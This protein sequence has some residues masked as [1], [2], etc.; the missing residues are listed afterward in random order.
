MS[1]LRKYIQGKD[2]FLSGSGVT[3]TATSITLTSFQFPDGTNITTSDIGS[4][5]YG[6][7]EPE[8]SRE[9]NFSFTTITQ[10]ADGTATLSGVTRGLKFKAPYDQDTAL[11]QTHAGGTKVRISNSVPFY[12]EFA[13]TENDE[14]ISQTW[15]FTNPNYPRM[16][17][18]T[19][20]PIDDEQLATKKYVDDTAGGTPVS[21]NR[22]VVAGT[23]GETVSAGQVVYLDETDNEWKLAD[24]STSA[25]SDNVQLGIA[26]GAG[27]NGNPITGGVLIV[28]RDSNQSG[29]SAGDRVYVGDT[30]GAIVTSAGTV[31]VELGHAVSATAI[32][33][34]PKFA[35]YTTKLQRD[36]LIGTSGTPSTSNKYVTADD[37]TEAKTASKIARRDSNSDILVATTPTAGDAATSK[38]YVDTEIS[39][40]QTEFLIGS[41]EKSTT[42]TNSQLDIERMTRAQNCTVTYRGYGYASNSL[43]SAARGESL[44]LDDFDTTKKFRLKQTQSLSMSGA[45]KSGFGFATSDF[46]AFADEDATSI[47][48]IGFIFAASN[49]VWAVTSTTSARTKT[50]IAGITVANLNTYNIV[51]NPGTNVLFYVNGTL[52][53]THTTNIPT[54]NAG[55]YVWAV[56]G[57]MFTSS[58]FICHP[59]LSRER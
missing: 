28:G 22:V 13:N 56:N 18:A 19:D 3:S 30:A 50:S 17:Q 53:A 5:A 7:F 36:A 16:D 20:A 29:L 45:E 57:T 10:N 24:A 1:D 2:Y 43:N 41:G 21:I 23:A 9:E 42:Y 39:D 31:E 27:T 33:F 51:W 4:L 26:Q 54:G 44:S 14:T 6:T 35:S 59:V 15:T 32:D 46:N 49:V 12:D 37:V 8:T 48:K 38:T 40:L 47:R 52:V 34:Q 58:F 25:T 55:L 11:R